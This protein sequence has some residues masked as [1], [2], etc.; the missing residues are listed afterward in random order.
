MGKPQ[1][2]RVDLRGSLSRNDAVEFQGSTPALGCG[3]LAPSPV[4]QAKWSDPS[5]R[6]LHVF[7]EGAEHGTRGARAPQTSESF[8]LR[9]CLKTTRGLAAM[10]F[11][12]S[13]AE[14]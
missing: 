9:A 6:P 2:Q 10:V 5:V 7:R 3:R 8:R 11:S 14:R 1:T 4:A 12:R 13:L